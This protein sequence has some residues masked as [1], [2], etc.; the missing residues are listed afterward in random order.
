MGVRN[1]LRKAQKKQVLELRQRG[2][3]YKSIA[4]VVGV[5]RDTVRNFCRKHGLQGYL[6]FGVSRPHQKIPELGLEE[7]PKE[8]KYCGKE[9]NTEHRRGRKSK[10]CSDKC[11]RR[12]WSENSDK[13]ERRETAWYSFICLY[14]GKDFKAYG[15]KNRKYCSQQCARDHRFGSYKEKTGYE[16][17]METG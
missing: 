9:I 6:Y 12:W 4:Y 11:R 5:S 13:K 14:C 3:G 8:C 10:F 17:R 1:K 15:N 2:Y 7:Y 16:E